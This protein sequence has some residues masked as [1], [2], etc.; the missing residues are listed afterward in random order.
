MYVSIRNGKFDGTSGVYVDDIL[1]TGTPRYRKQCSKTHMKFETTGDEE[2]PLT[3][4]GFHITTHSNFPFAMDQAFYIRNLEEF[5][6]DSN[7]SASRSMRMKLARLAS[8]RLDVLFEISQQAQV[9]EERFNVGAK[10]YIKRLNSSTKYAHNNVANLLFHKL[11]MNSVRLVGYSDAAFANNHDLTSLLGRII[12]L[13]EE[14][15]NAIPIVFKSYKS[16]RV[17][18]SVLSAEVIAFADLFD[19]AFAVRTQFEEATCRAVPMHLFTDS[20]SSVRGHEPTKNESW[21]TS[22]VQGKYTRH[23]RYQTSILFAQK[24]KLRTV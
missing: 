18:R 11:N 20:I 8:T 19:D 15:D 3:F 4:S 6:I 1:R 10:E 13:T 23:G 9:T 5:N 24:I 22:I 17:T 21:S 2:P 16:R 12:L 14:H 7:F